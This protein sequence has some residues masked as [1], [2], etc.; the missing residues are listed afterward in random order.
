MS[1]H[2]S[3]T[4]IA[5][6]GTSFLGAVAL[7]LLFATNRDKSCRNTIAGHLTEASD[8]VDSNGKAIYAK[9][10]SQMQQFQANVRQRISRH[11]PDLY[12]ATR[13]IGL[14]YAEVLGV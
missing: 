6:T 5:V 9:S 12:E 14:D 7:G 2:L 4:K 1:R 11:I 10:L 8:W 3:Y 13:H